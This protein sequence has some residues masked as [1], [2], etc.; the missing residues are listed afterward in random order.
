MK[1][2]NVDTKSSFELKSQFNY[3]RQVL[4]EVLPLEAP[5]VIY[6]ES[7]SYCN[8]EC[9]FCP[10]HISKNELIKKNMSVDLFR[11]FVQ[12]LKDFK[13]KPKLIR[14]CGLGDSL[15][16]KKF[17]EIVKIAKE[18]KIADRLELITNGILLNDE[19]MPRLGKFLDRVIVSI[20]GLDDEDYKK[21]TLRKVDF[22]KLV[23]KLKKFSELKSK[24]KLH[25]KIHNSAVLT[26][27]RQNKFFETFS[28]IADEIYIENLVNLWPEV[29]SNLGLEAGHRF[30][31]KDLNDV[32]VCPQIFKSMQINSDGRV[33]PCCIDW[34]GANL[35]GDINK[36][37]VKDIWNGKELHE[38]RMKHLEG[39]RNEFSPCKGCTMNEY[40]EKDNID[41]YA[42]QIINKINL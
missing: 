1:N 12:D 29:E 10:H 4:G 16:N 38:L 2:K 13:G 5:Y 39:K 18:N 3:K 22:S 28:N 27:D 35:I 8:L 25:I 6:I 36:A 9:K 41:D 42:D 19:I 23:L 32:K 26:K 37:S 34:K 17:V 14:F 15:F 24:A 30:D 21:Y 33:M 31:G 7:S 40:S 11:K 20:E